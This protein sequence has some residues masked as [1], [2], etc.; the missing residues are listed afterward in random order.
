MVEAFL[1]LTPPAAEAR[2]VKAA[3]T[4]QWL[5]FTKELKCMGGLHLVA[6]ISSGQ[7]AGMA[8]TLPFL[9]HWVLLAGWEYH[10]KQLYAWTRGICCVAVQDCKTQPL[11]KTCPEELPKTEK[12][13]KNQ[14]Q[15]KTKDKGKSINTGST[16]SPCRTK[17]KWQETRRNRDSPLSVPALKNICTTEPHSHFGLPRN[18]YNV[19]NYKL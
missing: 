4:F 16:F 11:V 7:P 5:Q 8:R 19:S 6:S 18:S 1:P 10:I 14:T 17:G 13:P 15:Q 12:N 9:C 2:M 3:G